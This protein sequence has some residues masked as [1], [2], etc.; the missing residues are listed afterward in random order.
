MIH[1]TSFNFLVEIKIS[2]LG[3]VLYYIW[4]RHFVELIMKN[5]TENIIYLYLLYQQ[6]T[7]F[8]YVTKMVEAPGY[9]QYDIL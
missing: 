8:I 5:E 3:L 9:F 7:E 4:K 2:R 1:L 6:R